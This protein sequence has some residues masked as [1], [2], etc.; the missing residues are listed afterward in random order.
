MSL[1]YCG[2]DSLTDYYTLAFSL[3]HIHPYLSDRE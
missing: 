2:G 1:V 3:Y